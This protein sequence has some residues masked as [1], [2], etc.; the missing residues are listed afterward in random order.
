VNKKEEEKGE[1][2]KKI[3]KEFLLF[4]SILIISIGLLIGILIFFRSQ[5]ETEIKGPTTVINTITNVTVK[6]EKTES[7]EE[8]LLRFNLTEDTIIFI[9]SDT[10]PYSRQ[11]F[12]IVD[13]LKK[14]YKV[15]FANVA[16]SKTPTLVFSCLSNVA[17]Y[18]AT[19]EFVCPAN[20]KSLLG[21]VEKYE[22]EKFFEDC[23]AKK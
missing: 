3:D 18:R 14:E 17:Q 11:M 2:G 8:C 7:M 1:K 21:A 20:G 5:S 10:C 4:F 13:E 19:P 12:G 22:L 16:D 15:Y 9:Y 23:K 6:E